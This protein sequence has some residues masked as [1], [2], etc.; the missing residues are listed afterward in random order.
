MVAGTYLHGIFDSEEFISLFIK[1][2]KESNDIIISE[3]AIIE[4]VS[5]YKDNEYDK[6]SKLFEENI[7]MNKLIDII[8]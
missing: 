3:E 4:K 1:S 8:K 7:D 2:L 6:L 5:E